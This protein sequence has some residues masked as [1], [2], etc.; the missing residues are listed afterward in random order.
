M[1]PATLQ[2]IKMLGH[3]L[4]LTIFLELVFALVAGINHK[5]DLSLVVLVNCVTNPL[6]VMVIPLLSTVMMIN[7]MR[8]ALIV[9]VVETLV[10]AAE[11][12]LYKRYAETVH[13]PFLFSLAAN[14]FSFLVGTVIINIIPELIKHYV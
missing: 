4:A 7:W 10:V 6:A 5:R 2:L 12:L 11:W 14:C 9:I 1:S 13:R 8:L 3:C